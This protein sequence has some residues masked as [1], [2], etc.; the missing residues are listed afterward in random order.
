MVFLVYMILM[1]SVQKDT[2]MNSNYFS[3]VNVIN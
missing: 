1:R 3:K 2:N